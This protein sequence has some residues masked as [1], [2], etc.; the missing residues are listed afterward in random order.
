MSEVIATAKARRNLSVLEAQALTLELIGRPVSDECI[1]KW[2]RVHGV[3][4]KIVGRY[5]VDAE[6][7]RALLG[8]NSAS[9]AA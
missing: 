3:G 2:C 6:R 7:L 8:G 4:R 9:E 1:R 5:T